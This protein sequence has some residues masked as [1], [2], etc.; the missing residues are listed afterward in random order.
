MTFSKRIEVLISLGNKMLIFRQKGPILNFYQLTGL[1]L[2]WWQIQSNLSSKSQNCHHHILSK[3]SGPFWSIFGL[4]SG[5][6]W[7]ILGQLSAHFFYF[8]STF[9]PFLDYFWSILSHFWSTNLVKYDRFQLIWFDFHPFFVQI[10]IKGVL[11]VE[12]VYVESQVPMLE[13]N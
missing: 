9:S 8:W 2:C 5:H 10:K 12:D 13:F 1:K 11:F 6:F 4:F 3:T 7:S